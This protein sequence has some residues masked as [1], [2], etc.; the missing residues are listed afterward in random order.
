MSF[1][2]LLTRTFLAESNAVNDT[3]NNLTALFSIGAL[4]QD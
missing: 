1:A 3:T 4:A 2:L